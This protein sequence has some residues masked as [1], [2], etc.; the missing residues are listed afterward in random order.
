MVAILTSVWQYLVVVLICISL[1]I[2]DVE[3]LFM[4]FFSH[5]YVFLGEMSRFSAHFLDRVSCFS[6]MESYELLVYFG[7]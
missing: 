6:G 1:V 2:S 4:C 7:S 3:H 5:M